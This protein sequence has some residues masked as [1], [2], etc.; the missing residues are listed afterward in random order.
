MTKEEV[1]QILDTVM[2]PEIPVLSL[3]KMGIIRDVRVEQEQV[4]VDLVPTF[5]GCPAIEMMRQDVIKR[6]EEAGAR[7]VQVNVLF[8]QAWSTNQM[9]PAGKTKLKEFGISPPPAF[10]GELTLEVLEKVSCPRCGSDNTQLM[11]SFGPTACRSIHHCNDCKETFE[12]MKP[13]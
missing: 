4:E 1:Y 7:S 10:D 3:V 12:Q 13:L 11:N 2:D 8:K 6:V 9:S 5:A